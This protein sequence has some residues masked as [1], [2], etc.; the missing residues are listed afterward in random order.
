ME[1]VM[2]SHELS[3]YVLTR[4]HTSSRVR[5]LRSPNNLSQILTLSLSVSLSLCL[6]LS[7]SLSVSLCV[8]LRGMC[9]AIHV[10]TNTYNATQPVQL[11]SSPA[12]RPKSD[13]YT[14]LV[15]VTCACGRA[16]VRVC[17]HL[18]HLCTEE[19]C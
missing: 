16:C 11:P 3:R 9:I 14:N 8:S 5:A 7:L 15:D 19:R 17:A 1:A 18:V 10:Y 13:V 2:Y 12:A 6:C 4:A